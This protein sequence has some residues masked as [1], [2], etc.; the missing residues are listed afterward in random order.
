MIPV[1]HFTLTALPRVVRGQASPTRFVFFFCAELE[2]QHRRVF[3]DLSNADGD[4]VDPGF[5]VFGD[6]QHSLLATRFAF[7]NK[8]SIQI[9]FKFVVGADVHLSHLGLNQR[10]LLAEETLLRCLLCQT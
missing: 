10:K 4:Q 8:L 9:H 2:S 6:V 3:A 7:F 5:H 1:L